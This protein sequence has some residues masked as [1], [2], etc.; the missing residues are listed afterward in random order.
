MHCIFSNL[1]RGPPATAEPLVYFNYLVSFS[2]LFDYSRVPDPWYIWTPLWLLISPVSC[3]LPVPTFR[4]TFGSKWSRI[5]LRP[6]WP[7]SPMES[8]TF[9]RTWIGTNLGR[10]IDGY[11]ASP[12]RLVWV[13]RLADYVRRMRHSKDTF[14][15]HEPADHEQSVR[16]DV[17]CSIRVSDQLTTE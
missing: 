11:M 4:I 16:S 10:L 6:K 15:L 3:I 2:A 7:H 8:I 14:K 9:A 1:L 12:T 13:R 17:R 5:D